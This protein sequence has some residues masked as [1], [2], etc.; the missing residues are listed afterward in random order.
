MGC[1][2]DERAEYGLRREKAEMAAEKMMQYGSSL[3]QPL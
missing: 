3:S 1:H 2:C